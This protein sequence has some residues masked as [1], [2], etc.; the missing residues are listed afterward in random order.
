M[1]KKR[2]KKKESSTPT[3]LTMVTLDG[4]S[5]ILDYKSSDNNILDKSSQIQELMCDQHIFKNKKEPWILIQL[6]IQQERLHHT[7]FCD[8]TDHL[9]PSLCC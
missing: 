9:F 6:I 3:L 4:V 2:I 7:T 1:S 5:D 8:N